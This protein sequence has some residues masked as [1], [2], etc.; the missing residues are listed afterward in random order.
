[1]VKMMNCMMSFWEKI[2]PIYNL[3]LTLENGTELSLALRPKGQTALHQTADE[4][5]TG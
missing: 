3:L 5:S 2:S 4:T 1:M